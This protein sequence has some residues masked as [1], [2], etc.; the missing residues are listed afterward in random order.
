M[1]NIK[2]NAKHESIANVI[3]LQKKLM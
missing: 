1:V 2:R 3:F